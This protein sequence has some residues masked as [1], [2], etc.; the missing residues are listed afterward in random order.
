VNGKEVKKKFR[1]ARIEIDEA[2]KKIIPQEKHFT[3]VVQISHENDCRLP[4]ITK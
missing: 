3:A 2:R 4:A 1:K